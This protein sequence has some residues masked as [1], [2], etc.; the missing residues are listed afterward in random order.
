M[1]GPLER[2]LFRARCKYWK[3]KISRSPPEEQQAWA[4]K[5]LSLHRRVLLRV[6]GPGR[7]EDMPTK[8][9]YYQ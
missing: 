6:F 2:E 4:R 3:A 9:R 8:L 7:L 1:F 5:T